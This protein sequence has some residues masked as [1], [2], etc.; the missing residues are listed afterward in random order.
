[1]MQWYQQ[2]KSPDLSTRA[3]WLSYKQ[4]SGSKQDEWVKEIMNLALQSIFVHTSQVIFFTCHKI[5]Q[6]GA[7][8][9]IS[10]LKKC[11]LWIFIILKNTSPQP[12]LNP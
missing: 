11:M 12:G 4:S 3:L 7:S 10:P 5:L 9:F 1:M 8:G 6:R 2:R